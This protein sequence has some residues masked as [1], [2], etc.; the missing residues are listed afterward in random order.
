MAETESG[1]LLLQSLN[2]FVN[3]ISS[4]PPSNEADSQKSS[5]QLRLLNNFL[6][7]NLLSQLRKFHPAVWS[8]NEK[9][10]T[11]KTPHKDILIQWWLALLNFLSADL[12]KPNF[13]TT[14]ALD[15]NSICM[16]C[17]SRIMGLT[18]LKSSADTRDREIYSFHLLMTIRWITN[19]LISNSKRRK[20]YLDKVRDGVTVNNLRFIRNYN[21]LLNPLIGKTIAFSFCYLDDNLHYDYDV[22]KF[23]TKGKLGMHEL[24]SEC[25][26]PWRKIQFFEECQNGKD[27]ASRKEDA[28]ILKDIEQKMTNETNNLDNMSLEIKKLFLVM[29]SYLQN[30]HVL[31][32]FLWHYWYMVINFHLEKKYQKLN[33]NLFP[34][35]KVIIGYVANILRNDLEN[36]SR[37]IKSQDRYEKQDPS[38]IAK[39]T[40]AEAIQHHVS[41]CQEKILDFIFTKFQFVQYCE[42]FR[43]LLG[44][45][46]NSKSDMSLLRDFFLQQEA[47]IL[48]IS[49]KIPAYNSFMASII[50]NNLLQFLIFQFDSLP[51]F[52]TLL[53]WDQWLEGLVGTIRTMNATSQCVG[54]ICLFNMWG[55][56]PVV[57][58]I[59]LIDAICQLWDT[60][61]INC[62]F[63]I[64]KI[65]FHK[66]LLFKIL[67]DKDLLERQMQVI[68][69]RLQGIN[70]ELRSLQEIA[71]EHKIALKEKDP[72]IFHNNNKFVLET[73]KP[74]YEDGALLMHCSSNAN[75]EGH[76]I[77]DNIIFSSMS[78]LANIRPSHI[79]HK[80]KYPFDICDELVSRVA[81]KVA[82][83]NEERREEES[84]YKK[85]NM[86]SLSLISD[87][88][89]GIAEKSSSRGIIFG[90]GP[91]L[92]FGKDSPNEALEN[93]SQK[94]TRVSSTSVHTIASRESHELF[95]LYSNVSSIASLGT[96]KSDSSDDL[97]FRLSQQTRSH[98][99]DEEDERGKKRKL[100]A[101][102]ELKYNSQIST[103]PPIRK[104]FKAVS[105]VSPIVMRKRVL[106]KVDEANRNW[107]VKTSNIYDKPLPNPTVSEVNTSI[108]PFNF[109]S[110]APTIE[111]LQG[112]NLVIESSIDTTDRVIPKNDNYLEIDL[113]LIME[114]FSDNTSAKAT[115]DMRQKQGYLATLSN[116]EKMRLVTRLTKLWEFASIFNSTVKELKEYQAA[117]PIEPLF[118]DFD[119][120]CFQSYSLN[121]NLA[122]FLSSK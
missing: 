26:L 113:A 80:G 86:S 24:P 63:Q 95:S 109:E 18:A 55:N 121:K 7:I 34:G 73:Q 45:F 43:S 85:Q 68:K 81:I 120:F 112:L 20:F 30:S 116:V 39:T 108:D 82:T 79:M 54:L 21:S 3:L 2:R 46:V 48:K 119:V 40:N 12:M 47:Q 83:R 104:I 41:I 115:D 105:L 106:S 58:R 91:V 9:K 98:P 90:I 87:D 77:A 59:V 56:I 96:S 11:Q 114:D 50:F 49:L 94:K 74:L 14:L 62:E 37:F 27:I 36:L 35:Y 71:K 52:I 61:S 69:S 5:Q 70:T 117:Q 97:L 16:E 88:S 100:L 93:P 25:L 17:I 19:R 76:Q 13:N 72:L 44:L 22:L 67:Q 107:G 15:T 99:I 103:K 8:G 84:K 6:R 66:L 23:L 89:Q 10:Q 102:P 75:G 111:E 122:A 28:L 29:I 60:L 101:P 32:N 64:I 31:M 33:I 65:L 78:R 4:S 38:V 53:S 51:E 42:C 57:N 110:F 92:G 118:I 1:F